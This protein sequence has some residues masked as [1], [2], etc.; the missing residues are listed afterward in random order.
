MKKLLWFILSVLVMISCTFAINQPAIDSNIT[1]ETWNSF[2]SSYQCRDWH[3]YY[4]TSHNYVGDSFF[5]EDTF[6]ANDGY[7]YIF[8]TSSTV[9][10]IDPYNVFNFNGDN[11]F[12]WKS[13]WKPIES[14][15]EEV[16]FVQKEWSIKTWNIL[17]WWYN[18]WI[19]AQI[20]FRLKRWAFYHPWVGGTRYDIIRLPYWSTQQQTDYWHLKPYS[21]TMYWWLECFNYIV[22]YCG[23]GVRDTQASMATLWKTGSVANEECDPND[24][25]QSNWWTYGCNINCTRKDIPDTYCWNGVLDAG[26]ECD[27]GSN[28]FWNGCNNDCKLMTPEC[29]LTV[30]PNQWN[31]PLNTTINATKPNWAIYTNLVFGDGQSQSNPAFALNHTYNSVWTFYLTLTVQNNYNWQINGTKPTATCSASVNTTNSEQQ[32]QCN[33]Q[34]NW[35]TQYTPNSNPW[36]NNTMNLCTIWTLSNFNYSWTPRTF[37]WNCV[38]SWWISVPCTA[39]QQRCW[40]GQLNGSES[41]DEWSLNGTPG[42]C[43]LACTGQVEPGQPI[44]TIEKE[45]ISTWTMEAGTLVAYKITVK[46]IGSWVATGVTIYDLLPTE[47]QYLNSNIS[48]VPNSTYHFTTWTIFTWGVYRDYILYT[49][50]TLDVNWTATVYPVW[51]VKSWFTFDTLTNCATVSGFNISPNEDCVTTTPPTPHLPHLTINKELLTTWDWIA[52][53]TVAYKITLTNDGN[54]TYYSAYILDILPNAIQY[55]TSSI[56]NI[57]DYLFEEGTTWNNEYYINHYNFHLTAGQSAIVYLTWVLKQ[58]FNYNQTTNCAMAPG[59]IDCEDSPLRP[60]PYI[61]KY[62]KAWQDMDPIVMVGQQINWLYDYENI[63]LIGLISEIS[64]IKQLLV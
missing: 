8:D 13:N 64:E 40:D 37:T 6:R 39:N 3:E 38:T 26:E 30:S 29:T 1:L 58:G 11:N 60:I 2:Y 31:I 36:L 19:A 55:Q 16:I 54:A 43:N 41:C 56:Q 10:V 49:D 59:T 48:I 53:N 61:Q 51:M 14:I 34:Y 45:Q 27:P 50:I 18:G 20:A 23:D 35:Q 7:Y 17:N 52:W 15:V 21:S 63:Y 24:P 12:K 4:I 42:H 57:S 46:N 32:P 22:H 28:N 44:L 33:S 9:E 5:L 25:T 47:L 62:Q